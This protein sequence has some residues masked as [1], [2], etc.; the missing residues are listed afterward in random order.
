MNPSLWERYLKAVLDNWL[1][2]ANTI[3]EGEPANSEW[4]IVGNPTGRHCSFA[5]YRGDPLRI[6][7]VRNHA[8]LVLWAVTTGKADRA[9]ILNAEL[10]LVDNNTCIHKSPELTSSA[11]SYIDQLL[12]Q[13]IVLEPVLN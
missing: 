5:N 6:Y 3:K 12:S 10:V 1:V 8:K 13:L 7:I 4:T 9:V 2:I 11:H